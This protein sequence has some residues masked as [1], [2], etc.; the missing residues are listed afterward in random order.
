MKALVLELPVIGGQLPFPTPY[1]APTLSTRIKLFQWEP[2]DT[3][4]TC[5][6][7]TCHYQ[8]THPEKCHASLTEGQI[9]CRQEVASKMLQEIRSTKVQKFKKKRVKTVFSF[10][11]GSCLQ[12]S[13]LAN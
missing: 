9:H 2:T 8:E 10:L 1:W 5:M 4:C 13:V 12:Y 7:H 3:G 6:V 11:N